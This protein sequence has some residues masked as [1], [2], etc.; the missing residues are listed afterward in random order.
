M[1]VVAP[2]LTPDSYNRRSSRSPA[3]SV[4]AP[5]LTPDSY[6]RE[7]ALSAGRA[8][9]APSLTPDSY[10]VSPDRRHLNQVVAPSLT[11]DSYNWLHFD[12]HLV[13]AGRGF[14]FSELE[15]EEHH[16]GCRDLFFLKKRQ[17]DQE[18]HAGIL[19]LGN[20]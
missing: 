18:F 13:L 12:P 10:N 11:P 9:V 1:I 4:V 15:S 20:G 14:F 7:A 16:L 6:N 3:T 5:S 19:L 8:V 17:A 2:S